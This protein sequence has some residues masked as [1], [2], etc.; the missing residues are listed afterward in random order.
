MWKNAD[1]IK[2]HSANEVS[3]ARFQLQVCPFILSGET[4]LNY[5]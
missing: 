3:T 4:G 2:D 5:D 1:Q